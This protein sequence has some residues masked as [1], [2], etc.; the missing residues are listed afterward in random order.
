MSFWND[1]AQ[2]GLPQ[3]AKLA[4]VVAAIAI[5]AMAMRAESERPISGMVMDFEDDAQLERLVWQCPIAMETTD[6]ISGRGRRALLVHLKPG[7]YPGV[8]IHDPPGDWRD[9]DALEFTVAAPDAAGA[10][11]HVRIDDA[12]SREDYD[13]R[14]EGRIRLQGPAQRVRIPLDE[15]AAAP[16]KDPLDLSRITKIVIYLYRLDRDVDMTID[17]IRL[18]KS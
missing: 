15:I 13:R 14:Y 2:Y 7:L 8:E 9:G 5:G 12:D 3:R 4:I 11:L 10:M 1:V 17:D 16:T 6:A 18:V